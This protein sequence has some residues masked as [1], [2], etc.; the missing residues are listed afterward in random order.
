MQLPRRGVLS[1][2]WSRLYEA[3]WKNALRVGTLLGI[4][5][6]DSAVLGRCGDA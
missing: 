2:Q 1:G 5:P 6:S 3:L 4:A